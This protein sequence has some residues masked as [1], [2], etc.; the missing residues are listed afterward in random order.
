MATM[1]TIKDGDEREVHLADGIDPRPDE[2]VTRTVNKA[3]TSVEIYLIVV[4]VLL[5]S[6]LVV[7]TISAIA[8]VKK[9]RGK[10]PET[11]RDEE[12]GRNGRSVDEKAKD[13]SAEVNQNQKNEENRPPINRKQEETR[14]E[15]AE[16][17]PLLKLINEHHAHQRE[18]QERSPHINEQVYA[19][20]RERVKKSHP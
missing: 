20:H 18:T 3:K 16:S 5:V 7:L 8:V 1:A 10:K 12:S 2:G 17:S 19:Y 14:E 13:D 11:G 4:L 15:T 9:L 6:M